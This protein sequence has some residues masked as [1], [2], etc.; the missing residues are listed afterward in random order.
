MLVPTIQVSYFKPCTLAKRAHDVH[1]SGVVHLGGLTD[2]GT[3]CFLGSELRFHPSSNPKTADTLQNLS[4]SPKN[5]KEK[6]HGL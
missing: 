6:E 4:T 3:L 1:M 5:T 2:D